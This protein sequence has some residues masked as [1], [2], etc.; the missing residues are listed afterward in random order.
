M[1]LLNL[2]TNAQQGKNIY[3]GQPLTADHDPN[4]PLVRNPLPTVTAQSTESELNAFLGNSMNQDGLHDNL[5]EYVLAEYGVYLMG[6]DPIQGNF[7]FKHQDRA[8]FSYFTEDTMSLDNVLMAV[9]A[10]RSLKSPEYFK[11]FVDW[12]KEIMK[13][14]ANM[15][16]AVATCGKTS[17]AANTNA[18]MLA[19]SM[20]HR[21]GHI[22]DAGYV[23]TQD[24]LRS[25]FDA[26][27]NLEVLT[28]AMTSV[29]T[30]VEGSKS[31]QGTSGEGASGLSA[32]LASLPK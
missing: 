26:T 29:T 7:P 24:H 8:P 16:D 2:I 15:V 30:L 31:G 10:L 32:L 28:A 5:G 18:L 11:I 19:S 3:T 9:M 22:D 27:F 14:T 23:K 25:I 13:Q 20:L 4:N 17:V 1:S 12:Q 6:F 21:S